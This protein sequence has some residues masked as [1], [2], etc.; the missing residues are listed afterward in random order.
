M[1]F[2]DINFGNYTNAWTST[3]EQDFFRIDVPS[4]QNAINI[5]TGNLTIADTLT[6]GTFDIGTATA[7]SL[8]FK[9]SDN[10]DSD[11][12]EMSLYRP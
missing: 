11:N 10:T 9:D 8:V 2:S 12:N 4:G 6:V 5:P 1:E 7:P 3:A